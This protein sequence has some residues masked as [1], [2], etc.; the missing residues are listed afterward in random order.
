MGFLLDFVLRFASV[1]G[2]EAGNRRTTPNMNPIETRHTTIH[3]TDLQVGDVIPSKMFTRD[4]DPCISL[5]GRDEYEV[6]AIGTEILVQRITPWG[7]APVRP[8]PVSKNP[9]MQGGHVRIIRRD[10]LKRS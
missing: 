2:N 3:K 9:A 8:L 7:T 6:V 5:G 1:T 10:L 4:S